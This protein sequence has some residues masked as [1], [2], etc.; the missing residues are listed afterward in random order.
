LNLQAQVLYSGEV[1]ELH[2]EVGCADRDLTAQILMRV[3]PGEGR[4]IDRLAQAAEFR[5]KHVLEC[6]LILLE[7]ANREPG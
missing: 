1:P 6:R 7:I 4:F 3:M 2:G 5:Y